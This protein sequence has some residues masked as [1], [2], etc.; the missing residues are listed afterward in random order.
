MKRTFLA[1]T[2]AGLRSLRWYP[3]LRV[4]RRRNDSIVKVGT[5][6]ACP[7]L[8]AILRES[9]LRPLLAGLSRRRGRQG[10]R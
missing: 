4:R 10:I 7:L 6:F 9:P 5:G 1:L 2:A 8:A 3:E